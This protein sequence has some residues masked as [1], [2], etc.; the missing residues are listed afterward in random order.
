MVDCH[1]AKR[2]T[3]G[4]GPDGSVLHA[5]MV[6]RDYADV[7]PISAAAPTTVLALLDQVEKL[8]RD[9]CA[10]VGARQHTRVARL[11]EGGRAC[12]I[13]SQMLRTSRD[14]HSLKICSTLE[15]RSAATTEALLQDAATTT[16]HRCDRVPV[17]SVKRS[18]V[19]TNLLLK[20]RLLQFQKEV[21]IVRLKGQRFAAN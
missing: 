8:H 9:E 3:A 21:A 7:D 16:G 11:R 2:L 4:R 1:S 19:G 15:V 18:K 10:T 5:T 20:L 13:M 14:R 6:R 17:S 12:H